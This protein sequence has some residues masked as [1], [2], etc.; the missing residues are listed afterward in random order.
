M[1]KL[2]LKKVDEQDKDAWIEYSEDF[3]RAGEF[4]K[5][6][7]DKHR[8]VD[9]A[10]K[11]KS[12]EESKERPSK[13]NIF[14]MFEDSKMIGVIYIHL[15][16]E[17]FTQ[18]LHDGSHISYMIIPSKRKQ[19]YGTEMLHLGIKKC[20]ELGL[21]EV[22]VSCLEENIGSY[23]MIENNC[24]ILL[25]IE[26]DLLEKDKMQRIYKIDVEDSLNKYNSK[27][28]KKTK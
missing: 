19:G 15:K 6:K 12:I 1:S 25:S 27:D 5:E 9:W 23:K 18:G 20:K 16:P 2:Y 24:G 10:K 13:L 3:Y 26:P 22:K 7:W 17:L 28:N 11:L 8:N 21:K 4:S 14:Y